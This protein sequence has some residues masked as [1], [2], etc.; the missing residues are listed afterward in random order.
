MCIYAFSVINRLVGDNPLKDGTRGV[1]F[2]RRI[3]VTMLLLFDLGQ[4]NSTGTRG[5][6]SVIIF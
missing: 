4:P 5:K 6:E 2:F 1:K 3:P